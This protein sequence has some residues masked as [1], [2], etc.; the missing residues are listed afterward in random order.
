MSCLAAKARAQDTSRSAT[1]ATTTSSFPRAGL[2]SV[3]GAKRDAPRM[4]IRTGAALSSMN[5]TLAVEPSY[6]AQIH[7]CATDNRQIGFPHVVSNRRCED[8]LRA[9]LGCIACAA[10]AQRSRLGRS[11]Y[12][13]RRA[14][15]LSGPILADRRRLV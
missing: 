1:A 13:P 15:A 11:R 12:A 10:N 14:A 7:Y 6:L 3:I 9:R 5:P 8:A 2:I 4:P